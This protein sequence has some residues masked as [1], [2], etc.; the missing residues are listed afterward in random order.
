MFLGLLYVIFL[1]WLGF[2]LLILAFFQFSLHNTLFFCL[3]SLLVRLSGCITVHKTVACY[4]CSKF[5]CFVLCLL[6]TMPNK[7]LVKTEFV[8]FSMDIITLFKT[9]SMFLRFHF[10]HRFLSPVA[11][12]KG[13]RMP[14]RRSRYRF[15]RCSVCC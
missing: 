14:I 3:F 6:F 8:L 11:K 7:P 2:C 12:Y 13:I 1:L 4:R 10:D 9:Q 15:L 5:E